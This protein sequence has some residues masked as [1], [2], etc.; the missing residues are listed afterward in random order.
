[1][2][3]IIKYYIYQTS[4][5]I[6]VNKLQEVLTYVICQQMDENPHCHFVDH[7]GMCVRL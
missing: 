6:I 1:M 4:C 5:K 7:I 3:E 2:N